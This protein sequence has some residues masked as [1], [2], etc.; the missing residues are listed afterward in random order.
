LFGSIFR[1]IKTIHSDG[2]IR[3]ASGS[4]ADTFFSAWG[5]LFHLYFVAVHFYVFAQ[6]EVVEVGEPESLV[7]GEF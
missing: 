3:K 5:W 2:S 7:V 6:S 4:T 1:L